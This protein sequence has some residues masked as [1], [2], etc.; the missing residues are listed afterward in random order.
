ML[1]KGSDKSDIAVTLLQ[2]QPILA[3]G[4]IIKVIITTLQSGSFY[5]TGE[6]L[7][8]QIFVKDA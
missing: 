6:H 3:T 5:F 7:D 8:R 1:R 2:R 4:A